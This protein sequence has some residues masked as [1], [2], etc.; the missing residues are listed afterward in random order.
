M[1]LRADIICGDALTAQDVAL[2]RGWHR[3]VPMLQSPFLSPEFTLAASKVGD[4]I[5]IA[6]IHDDA[7][8]VGY[9]PYQKR[10][11]TAYPVAAPMNDYHAVIGRP[12]R[13]VSLSELMALLPVR[14]L[15]VNSWLG[16]ASE[17]KA[18]TTCQA[19]LSGCYEVWFED[20]RGS[21]NKFFKDKLRGRRGM[22]AAFG[23]IHVKTGVRDH[24]LLD[25]LI[26]MKSEQYRR[27][28]R[29]DIFGLDWTKQL[30]HDLLDAEGGCRASLAVL[31]AGE[32]LL[33][34][35][36]SLHAD[37]V[38][39]FW[40]P[41]YFAEGAKYSPGIWLSLETMRLQSAH[42]YRSFDFG[43]S[44]EAYKKYLCNETQDVTEA[45]IGKADWVSG[46]EAV[47]G[48]RELSLSVR[49]RWAA[50]DAVETTWAGRARGTFLAGSRLIERLGRGES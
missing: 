15:S 9:F 22:E 6:R 42:G 49:R 2:W 16:P 1:S 34:L 13:P 11:G 45:V 32:S 28:G 21:N 10:G 40:F 37:G 18:M 26:R 4:G 38:W 47:T 39:H 5:A 30:L 46:L 8:L 43:F 20:Q 35:E 33:A 36:L 23:P 48:R 3:S 7:G 31:R 25:V 12:D 29:H 41:A 50:I 24:D 27:T 14:R 44:G 19:V 17:G